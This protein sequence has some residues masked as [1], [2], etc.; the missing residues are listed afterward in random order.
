MQVSSS[1]GASSGAT[2][3]LDSGSPSVPETEGAI[4]FLL[5][6]SGDLKKRIH[7]GYFVKGMTLHCVG[8]CTPY[9]VRSNDKTLDTSVMY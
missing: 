5:H 3:A 4:Y 6:R 9:N 7:L 2:G 8:S 1:E